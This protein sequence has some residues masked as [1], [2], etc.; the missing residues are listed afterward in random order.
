[1]LNNPTALAMTMAPLKEAL[2]EYGID[3]G[4]LARRVGIDPDLVLRPDARCPSS[5]IQKLWRLAA[6]Q[7]GD[8]VFGLRVG[9]HVRPACSTRSAS[10]SSAAPACSRR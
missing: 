1:M 6:E 4:E 10:E 9:Q 5:R 7:S 2:P 3:F 8:P